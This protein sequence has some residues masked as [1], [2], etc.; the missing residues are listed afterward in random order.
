MAWPPLFLRQLRTLHR[1]CGLV[2][3]K[4][5]LEW[6]C[7]P[8]L[9]RGGRG[10]TGDGCLAA[11]VHSQ[12]PFPFSSFWGPFL[13][14]YLVICKIHLRQTCFHFVQ[15]R[16]TRRRPR[17]P[18]TRKHIWMT[19][20]LASRPCA[21]EATITYALHRGQALHL[22]ASVIRF[23]YAILSRTSSDI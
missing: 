1:P 11:A 8:V 17:P 16:E 2:S 12:Y 19:R 13:F 14:V 10:G 4:R 15:R 20:R 7:C 23:A 21:E 9:Q 3:L 22:A 6:T 18:G 5:R